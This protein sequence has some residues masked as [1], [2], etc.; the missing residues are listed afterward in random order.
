MGEVHFIARIH[1][2][3]GERA[4]VVRFTTANEHEVA[5]LDAHVAFTVGVILQFVVCRIAHHLD[6]PIGI[7]GIGVELIAPHQLVV[8]RVAGNGRKQDRS[9]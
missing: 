4:V 8:L 5:V 2:A 6:I 3:R 7:E 9:K 1:T